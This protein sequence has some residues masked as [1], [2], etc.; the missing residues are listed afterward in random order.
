MNLFLITEFYTN[1]SSSLFNMTS[2]LISASL[3]SNIG[4][5]RNYSTEPAL[6]H[7]DKQGKAKMVDVNHKEST[8]RIAS[9]T[10]TVLVGPEI[11]K[12]IKKNEI[13]KGDVLS[14]AQLAGIIAAK[15][16]S[17]IIPLCH[18]IPLSS[19]DV[20]VKL[21]SLKHEINIFTTV[22]CDAKTG[23]EM[24][25]LVAATTAA[26]TIYDMC[27]AVSHNI[28]I[29]DIM[30]LEKTG[31]KSKFIREIEDSEEEIKL[32]FNNEPIVNKEPF[33]PLHH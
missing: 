28:I 7:I 1:K 20:K 13:K 19:V 22:S 10:A 25:A 15:R 18:N 8:K 33:A 6:T 16:T 11:F 17:E 3:N 9:A 4:Q 24:E 21:S 30:L 29:K 32:K 31:G 26:L 14:V 27:K 12:L 5:L 2:T 23:V